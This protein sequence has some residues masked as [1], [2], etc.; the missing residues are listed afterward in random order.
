MLP[1]KRV[2]FQVEERKLVKFKDYALYVWF[3]TGDRWALYSWER[4]PSKDEIKD[5]IG[6]IMR[7]FRF[8]HQSIT[9]P[10]F[11]LKCEDMTSELP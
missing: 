5:I 3:P 4:K 6:L 11:E 10:R 8:Y 1:N 2:L 9:L 7:S